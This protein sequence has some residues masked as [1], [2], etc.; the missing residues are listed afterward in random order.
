MSVVRGRNYPA[1]LWWLAVPTPGRERGVALILQ[2]WFVQ[3]RVTL[4]PKYSM[5][6]PAPNKYSHMI[7]YYTPTLRNNKT[8]KT[9]LCLNYPCYVTTDTVA[10]TT[11]LH[12]RYI[13]FIFIVCLF[14]SLFLFCICLAL[15]FGSFSELSIF[16]NLSAEGKDR[17]YW[18]AEKYRKFYL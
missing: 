2:S 11:T 10:K 7:T 1:V 16:R 14:W 3:G 13:L 15:G 18:A 5:G 6:V 17:S 8:E 4:P 12:E 9:C